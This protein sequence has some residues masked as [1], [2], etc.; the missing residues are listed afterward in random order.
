[1]KRYTLSWWLSIYKC[2]LKKEALMNRKF[3]DCVS[4]EDYES[5]Y[6]W[7]NLSERYR[8]LSIDIKLKIQKNYENI[9]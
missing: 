1:M 8:S 6:Y 2:C 4:I 9:T 5:S 3:N 7:A